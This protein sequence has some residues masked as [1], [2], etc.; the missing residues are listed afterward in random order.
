MAKKDEE[1][2]RPRRVHRLRERIRRNP[3]LNVAWRAGVLLAGSAV[4][5]GGLIMLVTPGPGLLGI[6]IGL[7]ILATEFTWAQ[8]ALHRARAAAERAR[9][10]A[11]VPRIRRRNLVLGTATAA[12]AAA[13]VTAYLALYGFAVPWNPESPSPRT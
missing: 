9:T 4:L 2:A 12:L 10:H 7:A 13:A 3:L 6:V 5:T 1:V 8:R 11:L